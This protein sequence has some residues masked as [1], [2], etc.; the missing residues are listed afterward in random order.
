MSDKDKDA[1]KDVGEDIGRIREFA[2][3]KGLPE[4]T[5]DDFVAAEL[6]KHAEKSS[7]ENWLE[8][9]TPGSGEIVSIEG[10]L[11]S[12]G[13]IIRNIVKGKVPELSSYP[14]DINNPQMLSN[15]KKTYLN[16]EWLKSRRIVIG[17]VKLERGC[18]LQPGF[19]K[20]IKL[21]LQDI[22]D[23]SKKNELV[24]KKILNDIKPFTDLLITDSWKKAAN[25]AA[26][27][28]KH[29]PPESNIA[30][31]VNIKSELDIEPAVVKT[32]TIDG[33]IS[34]TTLLLELIKFMGNPP[35]PFKTTG[36]DD[37]FFTRGG[38]GKK[39]VPTF[40][41]NGPVVQEFREFYKD[42]PYTL[43]TLNIIAESL[44]ALNYGTQYTYHVI[45]KTG[46][47]QC[48][49]YVRT[50]IKLIDASVK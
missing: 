43:S 16:P 42:D 12:V 13:D 26:V 25:V 2:E 14:N 8:K 47:S 1:A 41:D 32:L 10:F 6:K 49:D 45:A 22:T 39:G 7:A 46:Y 18:I 38:N 4:E 48:H 31:F 40:S 20:N 29:Q 37:L 15:I 44:K 21:L 36:W 34:V 11:D 24:V 19:E 33:I 28:K 30:E 3:K 50:M 9:Q 23:T 27:E 17:T 35:S 5:I